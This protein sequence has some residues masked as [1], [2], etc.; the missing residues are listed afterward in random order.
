MENKELSVVPT[1]QEKA[2]KSF[3]KRT[4]DYFITLANLTKKIEKL[5]TDVR[6]NQAINIGVI[7][8]VR[9]IVVR[10]ERLEK[11]SEFFNAIDDF[12]DDVI[13]VAPVVVNKPIKKPVKK[14]KT[15]KK[16]NKK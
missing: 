1:G 3:W 9:D 7:N 2:K 16:T 14:S 4:K 15:G 10:L 13:E 12:C 8:Y 11:E 6:I 5:E